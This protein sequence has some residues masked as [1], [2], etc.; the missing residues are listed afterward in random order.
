MQ[1]LNPI[2]QK[3]LA[4]AAASGLRPDLVLDFAELVELNR[5]A[6]D[7]TQPKGNTAANVL[8]DMPVDLHGLRLWRLSMGAYVWLNETAYPWFERSGW[9]CDLLTAFAMANSRQPAILL[10]LT[11]ASQTKRVLK[12]WLKHLPCTHAEL[13]EGVKTVLTTEEAEARDSGNRT[14]G[15]AIAI[16]KDS[17]AELHD[18]LDTL[19]LD[20]AGAPKAF[21]RLVELVEGCQVDNTRADTSEFGHVVAMLCREY[22]EDK[23]YWIWHSPLDWI[24]TCLNEYSAKIR[25]EA[26]SLASAKGVK[27]APDPNDPYIRACNRLRV[28]WGNFRKKLEARN[29]GQ[30]QKN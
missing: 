16:L 12:D 3:Q 11:D 17:L 27:T 1:Q 19:G 4:K 21:Q 9:W 26:K 20:E 7:I 30:C 29:E 25:A 5:I 24:G 18:L 15:E 6:D 14:M 2:V 22:G 28:A 23:E 10:A 8:L 13:M